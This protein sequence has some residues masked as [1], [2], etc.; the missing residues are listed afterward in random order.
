[1][2]PEILVESCPPAADTDAM[3]SISSI[4]NLQAAE[5]ASK[6]QFAVAAKAMQTTRAR[7]EAMVQLIDAAAETMNQAVEQTA[8]DLGANLDIRA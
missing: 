3:S 8:A 4:S 7:G 1:M 6:I 2:G 5:T